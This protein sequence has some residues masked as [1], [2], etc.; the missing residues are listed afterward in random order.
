RGRTFNPWHREHT[1]GGS[2]GGAGAALAVGL[3]PLAHGNDYGGSI[4]YP[5]YCCGV[6]GIR[7]TLGRVPAYNPSASAERPPSA[8]IMS[9]QGPMARRV[10]D[11]RLGLA[12]LAARDVRDPWWVPAPLEGPAPQ[13]PIRVALCP[14]PAGQGVH[15]AVADAIRAAGRALADAGYA[16]EEKEPPALARAI[17]AALHLLACDVRMVNLPD[18]LKLGDPGVRKAAS[19]FA[20]VAPELSFE[21]YRKLLSERA[22]LLRQWLVFLEDFPLIV[23]PVSADPPFR[24]GFDTADQ[25]AMT[26]VWRAQ[27]FQYTMNFLGLPAAAVP[28]G[29][30][31]N[32][33]GWPDGLP[34]GV[35]VI[36]SRFREDLVLDAAEVIE[37]KLGLATPIDPR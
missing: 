35:Q 16:V 22:G 25:A 34:L 17:E 3:A 10:R 2:S 14:D 26:K 7:P 28:A 31:K 6:G 8:Q 36:A 32:A 11:V 5:S 29:T 18:I 1:P 20:A 23:G 24:Y 30:T 9:V 27:R 37:A 12:A 4:R 13:R 33:E 15:P 19:L 21:D